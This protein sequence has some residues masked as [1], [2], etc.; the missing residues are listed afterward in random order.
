[1][2]IKDILERNSKAKK[3]ANAKKAAKNIAI[4][5]GIGSA[6]GVATGMLLAPDS[7]KNTRAQLAKEAKN[8]VNTVKSTVNK[9]KSKINS[10][11]ND[12]AKNVNSESKSDET[13]DVETKE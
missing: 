2:S 8:T 9:A 4:G 7:G 13:V 6:I 1:M 3:K 10:L 5:A 12:T 11:R